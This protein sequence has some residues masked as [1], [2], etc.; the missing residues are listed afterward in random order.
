LIFFGSQTC[1]FFFT[2]APQSLQRNR[3]DFGLAV[4]FPSLQFEP[5]GGDDNTVVL[6]A[7]RI[8]EVRPRI[9]AL[10]PAM[11]YGRRFT[12]APGTSYTLRFSE[13]LAHAD[14]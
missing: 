1:F 10:E 14:P 6:R 2:T 12:E 8:R 13:G 3:P 7:T 5:M 9:S 11:E 4:D